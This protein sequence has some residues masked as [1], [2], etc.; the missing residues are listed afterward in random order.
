MAYVAKSQRVWEEIKSN[1]N[2]LFTERESH[3]QDWNSYIDRKEFS[4]MCYRA[5]I[6]EEQEAH[7][8]A[9]PE[10]FFQRED[11]FN[12]R[13]RGAIPATAD[14]SGVSVNT[15]FSAEFKPKRPFPS[16]WSGYG[17]TEEHELKGKRLPAE[18]F[19]IAVKREKQIESIK[20]DKEAMIDGAKEL[21]EKAKSINQFVKLWE[22]ALSLL[23][24]DT[25]ERL[26]KKVERNQSAE[27]QGITQE[28]LA[29]LNA[30]YVK[31]KVSQ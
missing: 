23:D 15:N 1:I 14:D 7:M 31:A 21:Y 18:I 29:K 10:N 12:F 13:I 5:V 11:D 4:E 9:L 17:Y 24:S 28:H 26:R 20:A 2:R 3:A 25:V 27:D 22:P 16:H 19:N 30:G 6:T 8:H